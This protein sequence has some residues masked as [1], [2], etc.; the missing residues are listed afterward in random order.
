M[1]MLFTNDA[2]EK[3]WTNKAGARPDEEF[4]K[5]TIGKVREKHPDFLFAAE[6]YWDLEWEL[7]KQGFDFCYD[8]RL[9]DRIIHGDAESIRNYLLADINY[10]NGLIR[11]LENHDEPRAA[12]ILKPERIRAAAV[13]A[14]TLPGAKLF[15]YGQ[16]EGRK[17]RLPV[18]LGRGPVEPVSKE[19]CSF[20][21]KLLSMLR[22]TP[23]HEGEWLLCETSGWPYN[24][25]YRNLVAWCWSM[26]DERILIVVNHSDR[27]SQGRVRVPWGGLKRRTWILMDVLN[28]EDYER[29]GDE[30]V[31]QGLFIDL[32]PYGYHAFRFLPA[33]GIAF[34]YSPK[35]DTV[36]G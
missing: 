8:K 9:Y 29:D 18:Q 33:A 3:T 31:D 32:K 19:L 2:F 35:F 16:F 6:A 21:G 10:Q 20:Y 12:S 26:Q 4:W 27:E 28:D 30:M 14:A 25:T 34:G 7:Q 17:I 1:A 36:G 13:I 15:H 23:L 11:F 22:S 24:G 5:E